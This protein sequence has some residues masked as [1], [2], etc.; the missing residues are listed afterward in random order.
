L[1]KAQK[2]QHQKD[3]WT[4]KD[5]GRHIRGLEKFLEDLTTQVAADAKIMNEQ[6]KSTSLKGSTDDK[7]ESTHK[8]RGRAG[9]TNKHHDPRTTDPTHDDKKT[10]KKAGRKSKD[11]DS[12]RGRR[13]HS[14]TGKR[15]SGSSSTT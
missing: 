8:G 9:E 7:H 15:T 12:E 6:K 10:H 11:D 4:L 5:K 13:H 3:L 1:S 2:L 14:N